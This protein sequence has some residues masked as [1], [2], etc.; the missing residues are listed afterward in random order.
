MPNH[1]HEHHHNHNH[2]HNIDLS[3]FNYTKAF[4]FGIGLNVVYVVIEFIYGL[5]TN[6]MALISDA[7]HNLSDVLGLVLSLG[8]Y[9]IAKSSSS[10]KR[11]YGLKKTTIFAA[12][13]NAVIL[14]IALGIIVVESS[15]RLFNPKV[16][17][18][19]VMIIVASIGIII[20]FGTA[21]LFIKGKNKD[22]NVKS[23]FIH[24]LADAGISL[25]VV[26][27]A[28]LIKFTGY[29]IIDPIISIIIA[30]FIA[31]STLNLLKD[32]FNM[33]MDS[34][35][36]DVDLESI[37]KYLFTNNSVSDVHDLHVWAM[38]TTENALTVHI[39]LKQGNT[40][41]S[42][43]NTLSKEIAEKFGIKH[44]TIQLELPESDF[45]CE[46]KEKC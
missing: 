15:I 32:S 41:N 44:S 35:P 1:P 42:L 34:V 39:V 31:V 36:S 45:D 29:Y 22:L 40:D 21:L 37:R 20:N 38:S 10:L 17:Q 5:L 28:I 4:T 2:E 27:A 3:S 6:S 16:I 30:L 24:M 9:Y 8:A 11:T 33:L 14:I 25:G 46:L 23:S 13:L 19:N 26:I 43:I 7:G 18:S 12:H